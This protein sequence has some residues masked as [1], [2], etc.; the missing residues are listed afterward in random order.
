LLIVFRIPILNL[1]WEGFSLWGWALIILVIYQCINV[2]TWF[3]GII[4]NYWWNEK[5]YRNI[6]LICSWI[7]IILNYFLISSRWI[8][9]AALA[10]AVSFN[11]ANVFVAYYCIKKT[12][13]Y[14]YFTL[15]HNHD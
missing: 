15:L 5:L 4:L 8:A 13:I 11:I 12:G 2:F 14:P 7:N 10:T 9:W 1:F 6:L 3:G